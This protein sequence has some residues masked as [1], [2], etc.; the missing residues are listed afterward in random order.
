VDSVH[1]VWF[2]ELKYAGT[3]AEVDAIDAQWAPEVAK[4]KKEAQRLVEELTP[5]QVRRRIG[6]ERE[7]AHTAGVYRATQLVRRA[8]GSDGG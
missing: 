3:D 4:A 6:R 2:Q 5:E 8:F 7:S 1:E